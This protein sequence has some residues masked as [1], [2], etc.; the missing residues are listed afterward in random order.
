ML[1]TRWRAPARLLSVA[2]ICVGSAAAQMTCQASA[3]PR[4][5]RYFGAAELLADLV[6]ECTGGRA[7]A[8]GEELPEYQVVVSADVPLTMRTLA[9]NDSQSIQ[10]TE[11]LM[12][13]DEPGPNAQYACAPSAQVA[14]EEPSVIDCG[15][16]EGRA[17]VFQ[18]LRLQDNA[19]VFR[20]T[21]IAPP[22]A[23]GKRI[24][25]IVNLRADVR[26]LTPKPKPAPEPEDVIGAPP[27]TGKT[28]P[29]PEV[30]LTVRI[31]GPGGVTVPVAGADQ[32]AGT[33]APDVEFELRTSSD[34]AVPD[35]EP[36]LLSTPSLTPQG[37]PEDGPTFLIKFTELSPQVFRRRNVGTNGID[38]TFL[39][40]QASPGIYAHTESGFFNAAFP[41]VRGLNK[42]GLADSGTRIRVVFDDIP[43]GVRVWF[44]FREVETGTTGYDEDVPKARLTAPQ[45]G[46][47]RPQLPEI[48]DYLEVWPSNGHAE[49][50]WEITSS[51]PNTI[52]TL[53]FSVGL[54]GP[55]GDVEF[56]DA[57]ISGDISPAY[58]APEDGISI[59]AKAIPSFDTSTKIVE[60]RAAFS[61][62]PAL[63]MS[64]LVSVSAAG[65]SSAPVAPGSLVAGFG[66]GL[67]QVTL[68][69]FQMARPVLGTT[70][71]NVIDSSGALRPGL[72][73]AVSPGQVNFYLDPLTRSG[74]AVA[75]V[76]DGKRP[77]AEG[78]LQV[79]DVAPGLFSATPQRAKAS[80]AGQL[81]LQSNG[82]QMLAT[83]IMPGLEP[84][85]SQKPGERAY[86]GSLWHRPA[87]TREP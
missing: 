20:N 67:S 10:W 34:Q 86:P 12:L 3:E 31:F 53:A 42:A 15:S 37:R 68:S 65:Y 73:L 6:I 11:S 23:S 70:S 25:R 46:V 66:E 57:V 79:V 83:W 77:V 82:H 47:F 87:T 45:G 85:E 2:L 32:L 38:P 56:G 52:E 7:P 72:V 76:Y 17:N 19:V 24:L 78:L 13:V 61:L 27:D 40:S 55:N 64:Q 22:G 63:D 48:G 14:E 50:L 59:A 1:T 18:G 30:Y 35:G 9:E 5:L 33:L 41:N 28:E 69:A 60:P 75:T 39:A 49:A 16:N 54:T 80:L 71:V 84:R 29:A 58:A 36:A 8:P 4:S 43:P 74:A 21:P 26:E 51:D 62:V 44:S 81:V